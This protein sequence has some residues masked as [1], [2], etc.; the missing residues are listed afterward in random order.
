MRFRL[1]PRD[2]EGVGSYRVLY[3]YGF[4]EA[5]GGHEATVDIGGK[6][7]NIVLV[8]FPDP[9]KDTADEDAYVFQ[10]RWETVTP[11][12]IDWVKS[13]G[14]L[15]IFELDDFYHGLPP[16]APAN[17]LFKN[18][19]AHALTSMTECIRKADIVTV[20]TPALAEFYSRFNRNIYVLPNYLRWADW[21][22]VTP[23]FE[24][25]R[26][27]RVGWMGNLKFRGDDL[28]VLRGLLRPWLERNPH[29]DF[30][31][32]GDVE[33]VVHD[34]LGIPEDR[35]LTYTGQVFPKHVGPTSMLDIGLVPL[36][37]HAFNECKSHLKG[38]EYAACG[39][40]CIATPT[41]PYREWVEE[42]V[43]GFLARK[44][45]DWIRALDTLVN[46]DELRRQMGRNAYEK[47]QEH[48]HETGRW[49]EW[50]QV[51]ST[52]AAVN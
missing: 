2:F 50:E 33:P 49:R 37:M 29:V 12:V 18:T 21:R 20:S 7:G 35:R 6:Q 22:N 3:P 31:Q 51:V 19:K 52:L 9:E 8:N 32:V 11:S 46:D 39:I 23:A 24:K 4:M 13:Q 47:A 41:A 16:S 43:N 15:A 48:T 14:K 26:R 27:I 38:M 34:Y 36:T 1:F 17:R 45:K 28:A 42:G 30:A 25:D 10:C 44:A 5:E 40:P